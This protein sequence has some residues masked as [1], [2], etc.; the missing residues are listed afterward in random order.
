MMLKYYL[1]KNSLS[2]NTFEINMRDLPSEGNST[3]IIPHL[4]TFT[5]QIDKNKEEVEEDSS[6]RGIMRTLYD[7][8]WN[9]F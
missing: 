1:D 3:T 6:P 5:K 2:N 8:K 4:T 7:W 9:I